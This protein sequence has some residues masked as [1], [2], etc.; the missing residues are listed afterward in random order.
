MKKQII[1]FTIVYFAALNFSCAQTDT[2]YQPKWIDKEIA[3]CD[4]LYQVQQYQLE[5]LLNDYKVINDSVSSISRRIYKQQTIINN[6]SSDFDNQ[7][8]NQRHVLES[9]SYDMNANAENIETTSRSLNER[10]DQSNEAAVRIAENLKC[11]TIIGVIMVAVMLVI[12][13]LIYL[14]LRKR[15]KIGTTAIDEIEQ[16]QKHLQ[17]ES[18]KLDNKLV[19]LLEGQMKLEENKTSSTSTTPDHSF[20]L[21]VADEITRIENNLSRMDSSIRGYKQLMAS[22]KRIKDNYMANGYELVDMLGKPYNEGMIVNA[23]FVINE[24]L[25]EGQRIITTVTKPQVNYHGV[26]IQQATIT[27]SQNI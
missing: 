13:V 14:L 20:A 1:L 7:I 5:S 2:L 9:I 10:I 27:I 16:T 8:E 25:E 17:E 22:V 3:K 15:I 21:K 12:S 24:E 26:M 19:E 11:N 23:D 6:L 4:S 18:I